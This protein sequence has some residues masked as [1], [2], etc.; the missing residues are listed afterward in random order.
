MAI[1]QIYQPLVS[2]TTAFITI[3]MNT[4]LFWFS[5]PLIIYPFF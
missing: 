5:H 3:P 2:V 4:E 1:D